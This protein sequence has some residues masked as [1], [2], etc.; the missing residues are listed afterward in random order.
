MKNVA[1]ICEYNPFHNGHKMQIE[2]IRSAFYPEPVCIISLMSGNF[3]ERGDLACA[4]KY[5]RAEF[6]VNNG[7]DLVLELPFP[8]PLS[9]AESYACA[10]VKLLTTL[11]DV[12]YLCF[13]SESGR[14]EYIELTA[15]RLLLDDFTNEL[16]REA[17]SD[18]SLSYAALRERIYRRIYG[19]EL[20]KTPNDILA[21]EYVKSLKQLRSNIKPLVIKRENDFSATEARRMILSGVGAKGI[22]P[23]DVSDHFENNPA[24]SLEDLREYI[25]PHLMLSDPHELEIYWG[26]NYDLAVK[27]VNSAK[28]CRSIAELENRVSDKRYSRARVRRALLSCAFKIKASIPDA[29]GHA[30]LL[31]AGSVGKA[32]LASHGSEELAIYSKRSEIKDPDILDFYDMQTTA[33]GIYERILQIKGVQVIRKPFIAG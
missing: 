11:P 13:G 28:G 4:Q 19:E 7:A 23:F 29:P 32:Y 22:V 20:P 26:M 3:V 24:L 12:D 25:I 1:I 21:V 8:Y 5:Q 30:L 18:Y 10:A 15:E 2:E 9:G 16:Q 27:L 6:A 14:R 17:S 31:A 33:D